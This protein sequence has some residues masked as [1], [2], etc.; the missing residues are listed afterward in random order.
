MH[1]R[2]FRKL[3]WRLWDFVYCWKKSPF[4]ILNSLVPDL[5]SVPQELQSEF[6]IILPLYL[7]GLCPMYKAASEPGGDTKQAVTYKYQVNSNNVRSWIEYF[8]SLLQVLLNAL[9]RDVS[10]ALNHAD[11]LAIV[12]IIQM[13]EAFKPIIAHL[14]SRQSISEKL[15]KIGMSS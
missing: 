5:K 7:H 14:F 12:D 6:E 8:Q 4:D 2:C 1:R 15:S 3:S 10:A 9:L 11:T 13:M